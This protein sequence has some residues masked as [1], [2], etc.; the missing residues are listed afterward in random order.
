MS[1]QNEESDYMKSR[2]KCKQMSEA[3]IKENPKLRLVRGHYYCPIWG[4]QPH[5]WCEDE[6]GMV[7]DPTAKQ[8]PSK[9]IGEYIEFNGMCYCAECGKEVPEKQADIQGNYAFCSGRCHMRF[10]GL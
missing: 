1:E 7:H 6:Y 4:E 10:V 2:G 3:L 8:F 9:G 5:W